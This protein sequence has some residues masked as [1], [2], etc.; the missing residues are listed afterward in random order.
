MSHKITSK[1]LLS[2]VLAILIAYSFCGCGAKKDET[3]EQ[4]KSPQNVES[5]QD[6]SK[7]DE[8]KTETLKKTI[9]FEERG[10]Y[11]IYGNSEQ[12]LIVY[13]DTDFGSFENPHKTGDSVRLRHSDINV[14][15]PDLNKIQIYDYDI[16]FEQI[17]DGKE[18]EQKLKE[19]CGNF[20]EEKYLIED[21]DVYLIKVNV[22]YN[23][24]SQIKDR[25]PVDI[26][27]A[28]VN[29]EGKYI[30]VEHRLDDSRYSSKTENG[31]ASNWYPVLVPKGER[32][33]PVF[34]IGSPME[35]PGPVAAVY[36]D[37]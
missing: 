4:S 37:K 3:E 17:L 19:L 28:A 32:I 14:G 8:E 23:S 9:P 35:Y 12:N 27:V 15:S 22:K 33:K 16:T 29:Y 26:F 31:E 25:L 36:F 5:T 13:K 21:N 30:N 34:A 20:D 6:I 2:F 11:V 7:T 1:K 18:A 10:E 24:D